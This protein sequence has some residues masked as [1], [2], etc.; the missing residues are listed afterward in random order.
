MK[1]ILALIIFADGAA[2]FIGFVLASR[3]RTHD[4]R[5]PGHAKFLMIWL[6]G[7]ALGRFWNAWNLAAHG[8]EIVQ[9]VTIQSPNYLWHAYGSQTLLAFTAWGAT[10]YL[11]SLLLNGHAEKFKNQL[12]RIVRWKRS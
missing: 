2:A 4:D 11:I 12:T 8:Q 10:F 6:L 1:P 9:C 3:I 7:Y 5:R